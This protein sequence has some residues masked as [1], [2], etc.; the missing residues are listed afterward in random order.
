MPSW[1]ISSPTSPHFIPHSKIEQTWSVQL[2]DQHSKQWFFGGL[3]RIK[4]HC[5]VSY[6][7]VETLRILSRVRWITTDVETLLGGVSVNEEIW[8]PR[9]IINYRRLANLASSSK[10][11]ST[12][13]DWDREQVFLAFTTLFRAMVDEHYSSIPLSQIVQSVNGSEEGIL[14][15]VRSRHDDTIGEGPVVESGNSTSEN[16]MTEDMEPVEKNLRGHRLPLWSTTK[17]GQRGLLEANTS[18]TLTIWNPPFHLNWAA[19]ESLF[20]AGNTGGYSN[21]DLQKV[22]SSVIH[23]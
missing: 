22:H 17:C 5:A 15:A 12:T 9:R 18:A 11:W 16:L 4:L 21:G 14:S 10:R 23:M 7:D 1:S 13:A 3:T 8:M 19:I 6:A 2:V 20:F